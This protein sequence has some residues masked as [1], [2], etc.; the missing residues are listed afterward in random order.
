[1]AE[2]LKNIK[3]ED[4]KSYEFSEIKKVVSELETVKPLDYDTIE[5]IE[6][7]R[8]Y[9]ETIRTILERIDHNEFPELIGPE[10]EKKRSAILN[11]LKKLSSS[12]AF[13]VNLD[14]FYQRRLGTF[15]EDINDK[16]QQ[17]QDESSLVQK[18][19]H[20]TISAYQEK[21]KKEIDKHRDDVK[22]DLENS[23]TAILGKIASSEHESL[24]NMI[25]LMGVF[26]AI[27]TIIMSLVLTSSSWLNNADGASALLAFIVPTFIVILAIGFLMMI[28]Y[29][30]NTARLFSDD[31]QKPKKYY[32]AFFSILVIIVVVTSLL[33]WHA[34]SRYTG[35]E[36]EFIHMRYILS[37]GEYIIDGSVD[38][39]CRYVFRIDGKE[40]VFKYNEMH[41]HDGSLYYC[42]EHNKLE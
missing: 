20:D 5:S 11:R 41:E 22:K 31:Q 42:I 39:D 34:I 16:I 4:I 12:F 8:D 7:L 14:S 40:Y 24:T 37:P 26:S 25:T 17:V 27:I 28:I 13:V 36:S 23:Q 18:N 29:S 19:A 9:C 10:N 21:I 2:S 30:Y 6:Y 38:E 1:M 35:K 15:S 3:D 33:L 32:I